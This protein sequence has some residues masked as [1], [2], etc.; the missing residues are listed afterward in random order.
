MMNRGP[1]G[2]TPGLL[3]QARGL[4]VARCFSGAR[5]FPVAPL[6][7]LS[8]LA[9]VVGCGGEERVADGE[10]F[11]DVDIIDNMEDGTQYILSDDG[12]IGLWY[13]Y[14]DA[15]PSGTQE[16]ALGFPMYR[17]RR[18]DG[19]ADPSSQVIPRDC[20]SGPF[21]GEQ[22]CAFVAR[23]WGTGQRGWGAG[24]G[25]DLNGEGGAKNPID[26]SMYGGIGFFVIGDVRN[27]RIR[28]NIQD[29]RTTPESAAA[30]DRRG[31]A[32][33]ESYLPTG[34][35]T[36]RCNDHY[37]TLVNNVDKS[38]WHWVTIPFHCMQ[39]GGWGYPSSPA[40]NGLPSDNVLRR[41]AIVGIQFQ[42][43][44]ADPTDSGATGG[45]VQLFDFS[46][47]NLSFLDKNL[48]NDDTSCAAN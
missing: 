29:V 33:C 6:L 47:D 15:S 44:G 25:V 14:N 32:R 46:I 27:N 24:M 4:A 38:A 9:A 3:R 11:Q 31:I 12:R 45:T 10:H 18:P 19:S 42:I 2:E 8:A 1:D 37:G 23:T 34:A 7:V 30:A 36:G 35:A 22:E 48:V 5:C 21:F 13:T 41:D 28:V 20:G 43:E 39:A 40:S 17:T 26:A 16:P